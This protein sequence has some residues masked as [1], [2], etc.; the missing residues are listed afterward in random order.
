MTKLTLN[1]ALKRFLNDNQL[2]IQIE[3]MGAEIGKT[4]NKRRTAS[5]R[6]VFLVHIAAAL[7]ICRAACTGH[8]GN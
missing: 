6:I 3:G 2:T 8:Y 5:V 4:I 7:P 1:K